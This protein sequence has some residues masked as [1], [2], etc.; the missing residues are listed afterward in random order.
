MS[1]PRFRS[2]YLTAVLLALGACTT[3]AGGPDMTDDSGDPEEALKH[4]R[5]DAGVDARTTPAD[6]AP[7]DAGTPHPDAMSPDAGSSPGGDGGDGTTGVVSCYSEGYPSTTC[8]LPT[9]CCFTNYSSQHNGECTTSTCAW[10][11][12]DCDGPEDCATG[13]H[14]CAHALIDPDWGMLG[15]K[16]GCQASACGAAPINQEL[17]HPASSAVSTCSN[18]GTCVPALGNDNDLPR[19]LY[20]CQ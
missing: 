10:G 13:Q 14:C 12:M 18:G 8:A 3:P 9:H 15:Y 1:D 5:H 17:C 11:T 7:T 19:T 16:L 20:I 2:S 6:A 4:P